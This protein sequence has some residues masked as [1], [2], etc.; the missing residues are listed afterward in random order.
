[1]RLCKPTFGPLLVPLALTLLACEA[2]DPDSSGDEGAELVG[3]ELFSSTL[4]SGWSAANI[5][6]N[7]QNGSVAYDSTPGTFRLDAAGTGVGGTSDAGFFYVSKTVSGDAEITA[8]V[9]NLSGFNNSNSRHGVMVRTGTAR[10]AAEMFFY[11]KRDFTLGV[12]TRTA[13][14]YADT[15]IAFSPGKR[16]WLKLVRRGYAIAPFVSTDGLNWER[17]ADSVGTATSG[18]FVF[19]LASC[20]FSGTAA[21]A[22]SYFDKVQVTT[23]PPPFK[24]VELTTP[25]TDPGNASYDRD[26]DTFTIN[27]SFDQHFVY[28]TLVGDGELVA[29]VEAVADLDGAVTGLMLAH[30]L[31]PTSAMME[32]SWSNQ[33]GVSGFRR[34]LDN[35]GGA[36]SDNGGPGP[37]LKIT[38]QGTV[39]TAFRSADGVTWTS[40]F[41]STSTL[42]EL[43]ASVYVGLFT[44]GPTLV[45]GIQSHFKLTSH[46]AQGANLVTRISP[47][48]A[49][50]TFTTTS[51]EVQT[52]CIP[53]GTHWVLRWTT[54]VENTGRS[55]VAMGTPSERT[56]LMQN[57]LVGN[58]TYV[59]MLSSFRSMKLF[60]ESDETQ[61]A[62]R[63][64]HFALYDTVKSQT[65]GASTSKYT[66]TSQGL[67]PGWTAN[68]SANNFCQLF[69]VDAMADGQYSLQLAINGA[70]A[71]AEDNVGD[72]NAFALVTIHH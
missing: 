57:V 14:G 54:T 70:A 65:W 67:S 45:T 51:P 13:F 30:T 21:R 52:H 20:N 42:P 72:D 24:E 9:S 68:V 39:V 37:W 29:K 33:Y 10:S 55:A 1:M 71:V 31:S 64:S 44:R 7:G 38:R 32:V 62:S 40:V 53:S 41:N 2:P 43:G 8:R 19:G 61:V 66:A 16:V 17:A 15:P 50:E 22:R 35:G 25:A 28:R 34:G 11:Q 27:G 46:D 36:G 5:G 47:R 69:N 26:T 60:R 3:Q 18:P 63:T 4:P 56:D 59:W 23:Q 12:I 6:T 58:S 48:L 49:K